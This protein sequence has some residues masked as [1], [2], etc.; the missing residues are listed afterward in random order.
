MTKIIGGLPLPP[1]YY[2]SSEASYWREDDSRRWIKINEAY[3]KNFIADYGYLKCPEMPG[4]NSEVESCVMKI[5]TRQ[6]IAYAGPLA[7]YD[8]GL[9]K[10]EANG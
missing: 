7:G 6:N 8:V 2:H 10:L 5:Q 3:A 1:V 9:G 4:T